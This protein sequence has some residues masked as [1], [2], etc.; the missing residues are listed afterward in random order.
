ME[1]TKLSEKEQALLEPLYEMPLYLMA[2]KPLLQRWGNGISRMSA[3]Q[4][5]DWDT[6]MK[7]R[8]KLE[9]IREFHKLIKNIND[10]GRK[11]TGVK[12]K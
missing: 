1:E 2:L 10:K 6:I 8:G 5:Q 12:S 4:A 3:E 11:K 7:N 9:F